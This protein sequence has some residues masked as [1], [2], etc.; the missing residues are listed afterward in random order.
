[1]GWELLASLQT[2]K[3]VWI[4]EKSCHLILLF[5]FLTFQGHFTA[6]GIVSGSVH[7]DFS[8]YA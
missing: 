6:M 3:A 5:L 4:L 1:M 2:D 7:P 8:R